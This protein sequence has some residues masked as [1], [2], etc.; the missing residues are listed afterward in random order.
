MFILK[1]EEMLKIIVIM[2]FFKKLFLVSYDV[3][4]SVCL[5]CVYY[6]CEY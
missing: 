5:N 1:F 3:N 2:V 6:I 4:C